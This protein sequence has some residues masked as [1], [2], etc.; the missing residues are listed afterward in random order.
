MSTN[1]KGPLEGITVVDLTQVLAGPFCAKLLGDLGA[2]VIKVEPIDPFAAKSPEKAMRGKVPPFYFASVHYGKESIALDLKARADRVVFEKML[3]KADILVQNYRP[4]VMR[5]FSYTWQ[6]LHARFPRLI[7]A[8]ISGFGEEGDGQS[9]SGVPYSQMPSM[10]HI[11]QAMSGLMAVTGWE[12]SPPHGHGANSADVY[13][14]TVAAIGVLGALLQRAKDGKGRR[15]DVSMLDASM[16]LMSHIITRHEA[17]SHVD[18]TGK[19][20]PG[21]G[22]SPPRKGSWWYMNA[23]FDAFECKDGGYLM[24]IAF[25]DKDYR[26]LC[27]A[28]DRQDLAT[29]ERFAKHGAR[30]MNY[31]SQL[32]PLICEAMLAKTRDEWQCVMQPLGIV[33]GP[34]NSI[35][36]V[37]RNPQLRS[38]NMIGSVL[39]RATGQNFIVP[40][41]A[42]KISGFPDH[43]FRGFVHAYNEDGARIRS[44]L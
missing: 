11:A 19:P 7:Y 30:H 6:E 32:K 36:E 24:V 40:G 38:R 15:V 37:V 25:Q 33:C 12:G 39:D 1:P 27:S 14:G 9:I 3:S 28:I 13:S 8:A 4:G 20:V 44:N 18:Q 17:F 43:A 5:S 10:D 23:V 21:R 22:L 42:V 41:N 16:T 35:D 31:E 29:D 26:A 2:R 34:V